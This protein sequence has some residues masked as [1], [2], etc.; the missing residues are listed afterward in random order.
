MT[1]CIAISL[2]RGLVL[3]S[4]SRTNAGPD[5]VSTYIRF[6]QDAINEVLGKLDVPV[7]GFRILY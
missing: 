7:R 6:N 1:Y 2:D 3:T 4:D 5:R